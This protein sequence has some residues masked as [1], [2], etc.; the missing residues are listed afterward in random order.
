MWIKFKLRLIHWLYFCAMSWYPKKIK[1]L[2][3]WKRPDSTYEMDSF[4]LCPYNESSKD[5]QKGIWTTTVGKQVLPLEADPCN[6]SS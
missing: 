2:V 5:D 6:T 4:G 3:S 1:V